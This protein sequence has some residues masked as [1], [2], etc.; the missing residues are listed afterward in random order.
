MK[1]NIEVETDEIDEFIEEI[2]TS[3]DVFR[4]THCGYWLRGV[5]RT[6]DAGW[7]VF[8]DES[9]H[10][11]CDEAA[12]HY[13]NHSEKLPAGYYKLDRELAI[14]AWA[15]GA[16]KYGVGWFG[17]GDADDWDYSIQMAIFGEVVYG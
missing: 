15:E 5:D 11:R 9:E 10:D 14:K 8:D 17:N 13:W 7:L 16:K 6:D 2:T 3:V 1:L 12:I 4:T